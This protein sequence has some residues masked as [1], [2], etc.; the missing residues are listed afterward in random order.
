M[1]AIIALGV[2]DKARD[3]RERG[4]IDGLFNRTPRHTTAHALYRLLQDRRSLWIGIGGGLAVVVALYTTLFT[5]MPGLASG[6]AGALGYWLG[7]QDVQRADQPWFYYMLMLPQY[8]FVAVL[9]FPV[10]VA[11]TAWRI[12]PRLMRR[13]PVGRRVYL[14]AFAIYWAV[15]NLAVFSWAGE[16]M[17]WLTVH[18]ALPLIILAASI[19][20]AGAERIEALAHAGRVPRT[21]AVLTALGVPLI[22][23]GWFVLWAWG[24]AGPWVVKGTDLVRT[25]RPSIA[26]NPWVLYLPLLALVAL[27][28]YATRRG[29]ARLAALIAGSSFV[30]VTMFAQTHV[31]Y[32]MAYQEGD[33]PKDM[34][35]YVQSSPDVA[36]VVE[37]L[38]ILS[39]E[40]TGGLDMPIYYD[41][42]TSWPFQWYLRD[43]TQRRYF[44]TT[45]NEPPDTPIVLIS[46]EHLTSENQ[47]MLAGYTYVEYAMRWWFPEDETYRR[48]AIAPELNKTERQNYQTA[49]EG[50]FTMLDVAESVWRSLWGMHEPAEQTK[51]FRLLAFREL[52]APIGSYNFRVYVRNDLLQT[53]ND[54]RY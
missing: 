48:F 46:N 32:R 21:T 27:L 24:S 16:K 54:I 25:P 51:M 49:E 12:I 23:A 35:I 4:W 9:L 3:Q 10:A 34:L 15:V 26:D 17:P 43:Y 47:D 36:R 37:E 22:M 5:N 44:G 6:T 41:A 53:Y 19:I 52:W 42:G 33:V 39:R 8:E 30:V 14:R 31:A 7:Q 13:E 45:L 18:M 50:P 38:G 11:A 2:L 29:G 1:G 20:G 28:V 40:L